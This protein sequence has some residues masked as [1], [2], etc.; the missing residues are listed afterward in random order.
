MKK[1]FF[2][3]ALTFMAFMANAQSNSNG[4]MN[5]DG[6]K[7]IT[8]VIIL[9]DQILNGA[10]SKAYLT[11]PDD[12]HPHMIDLG[13]PSGTKWA[14]CNVGASKP[15]TYGGYYAWGETKE[16]SI[17]DQSTYTLFDL[18]EDI[19]GT[20]YDVAHVKWGGSWVLPSEEQEFEL[21]NNC[22]YK[23]TTMNGVKGGK[24]TGENGGSIFLPA[25]GRR[26]DSGL[27]DAG[28]IGYYWLS[29]QPDWGA[30]VLASSFS[31]ESG[32]M[33]SAT[34][35][36]SDGQSVRPV[37]S[38]QSF[39]PNGD[40]NNDG[41]KN[42][43]DVI[44]LVDEILNGSGSQSD[45]TCP[46]Y[47]HPHMIDLGLPSGTK[48][49]CCN[50]GADKPE[51]FGGHYA[52]GETSEKPTYGW[53]TYIHSDGSPES[54]HDI[55]SD[56]SGTEYDVAHVKWGGSWVMPSKML[57][58]ELINHCTQEL[59]YMN[60]VA[61]RKFTGKNGA[62]I[63]MPAA[64]AGIAT[65]NTYDLNMTGYYWS[66]TLDTDFAG[67]AF[68]LE[69]YANDINTNYIGNICSGLSVRPVSK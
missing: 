11:C 24:F 67:W 61:G 58:D 8:D 41:E 37:S 43:T 14:C 50:V 52:W 28:S 57:M 21:E 7:N 31:F 2:T 36:C 27:N 17:Y 6:E 42:I 40:M 5:N 62:S 56:I 51:A 64:E 15:T 10:G 23:W 30:P 1:L 53:D 29:N 47:H 46:D 12:H 68:Y 54:C 9:V 34:G 66:S 59:A 33:G 63:F 60:G 32:V 45:S 13:L 48:W 19:A 39:D 44:L 55:G 18:G 65:G 38:A 3:F 69:F 49:A 25:A 26:D 22:T 20:E 4:D 35:Y 16:K